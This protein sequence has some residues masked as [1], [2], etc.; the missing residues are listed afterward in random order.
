[1]GLGRLLGEGARANVYEW[2]EGRVLKLFQGNASAKEVEFE[3]AVSRIVHDLGV[4]CPQVYG[5]AEWDKKPGIE[6]E[7]IDGATLLELIVK[8]KFRVARFAKGMA[9]FHFAI[10]QAVT[11]APEIPT[12]HQRVTRTIESSEHISHERKKRLLAVLDTLPEGEA[13]CHGDFYP[14]NVMISQGKHIAIDW[15]TVSRGDKTGD[16]ARTLMMMGSPYNPPG[17]PPAL[18]FLARTYKNII[19][20]VYRR[21]ILRLAKPSDSQLEAWML[22]HYASRLAENIPG[23]QAWLLGELDKRLRG[24]LAPAAAV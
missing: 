13:V 5:M 10:L 11:N 17:I 23:E 14:G 7:R 6:F 19:R 24:K 8:H 18:A 3:L 21:E 9:R 16:I 20:A 1:M 15:A 2:T 12:Q 4:P 22:L